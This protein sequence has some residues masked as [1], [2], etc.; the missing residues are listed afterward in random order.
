MIE[1]RAIAVRGFS[2]VLDEVGEHLDVILVDLRERFDDLGVFAVMRH[3]ME[4]RGGC[5]ACRVS[6]AGE[7]AGKEQRT[8][9]GNVGLESQGEEIE[10]QF[11]MFVESLWHA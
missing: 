7:V 6:P 8:H 1:Q 11:N 9:A 5:L 2:E 10:L 4:A 3:A